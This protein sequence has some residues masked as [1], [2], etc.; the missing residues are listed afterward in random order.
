MN[1]EKA[2]LV[3]QETKDKVAAIEAEIA[4]LTGKDNKKARNTKSKEVSEL[5]NNVD[6]VDAIR[7]LRGDDPLQ[8]HNRINAAAEA[9]AKRIRE[10]EAAE[11]A[12]QEEEAAK[13]AAEEEAKK[14]A[15]DDSKKKK[16]TESAGISPTERAELDK[17]KADIISRKGELKAQGLSG[18][19]QNKDPQIVEW[20]ARMNALK[21]KA[22]E[23]EVKK[24]PKKDEK[25]AKGNPEE[26]R[27]LTD[28]L[29]EYK[30]KLRTEFSYTANEVKKDE[31][32]IEMTK[33][34][35]AIGG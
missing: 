19:Q 31:D 24:D 21:E 10:E 1:A 26:I 28:E 14:K 32:V 25:K 15:K 30:N 5:K 13:I 18:G 2:E 23:L 29:E 7:V 12:R 9:E 11:K 35:K 3:I 34:L 4:T 20:V 27:K 16:P 17:L 6:Y 22:G 8:E 33:K